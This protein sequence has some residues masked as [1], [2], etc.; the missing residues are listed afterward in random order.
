MIGNEKALF[1]RLHLL[2]GI[3]LYHQNRRVEAKK[4]LQRTRL[5]L[6]ALKIDE[7]SICI[8]VERGYSL[9]E[10]RIALRA[11]E[12]NVD[13]AMRFIAKTRKQKEDSEKKK[14]EDK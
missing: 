7:T 4:V 8:L 14:E 11:A 10:S 5:E 9:L 13:E 6:S 3:M 2:Q 12:G 1:M